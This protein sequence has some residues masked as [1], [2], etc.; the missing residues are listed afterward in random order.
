MQYRTFAL[1][2]RYLRPKG[3]TATSCAAALLLLATGAPA[4]ESQRLHGQVPEIVARLNPVGRLPATNRLH[5][6]L[7]LPLRNKE[8][9]GSLLE[10]IYDP[11][12]TNFHRYLVPEQFAER[13][14]PSEVDY[15]TLVAFART[16]GLVVEN[17]HPNRTLLD[18]MASVGEIERTLHVTMRVYQHPTEA[19]TFYA[20]DVEPSL[21]L[22][23]PVLQISGLDDYAPPRSSIRVKSFDKLG[24][25]TENFGSGTNGWYMGNDFRAAY[26]PGVSLRGAGQTVALM[27]L[28][29]HYTNDITLYKARAGL[30]DVPV[31][32]VLLNGVTGAPYGDTVEASLDIE[33]VISM[34]P[35]ISRLIVYE[36]HAQYDV[37]NR[38]ATDNLAKQVSSSWCQGP[39]R[40]ALTDQVFL[41]FAA[42]GQ[43]GFSCSGDAGALTTEA[44]Y[45]WTSSFVTLVGGTILTTSDIGGSR[46]SETTWP[47]SQGGINL[48]YAIPSWQQT[49][50]MSA[51]QG[52]TT[53]RNVP[54]VAMVADGVLVIANNGVVY[55]VG[56]TSVAAPLWAGFC[57]LINERAAA[58]GQPPVGFLNPALYA[59]GNSGLYA[60]AFHDITAG[61]N[62]NSASP[63]RWS[64]VP[65]YDL[66]TGWGTPTGMGTINVLA[67]FGG[68]MWVDFNYGGTSQ[69]GTYEAPYKTLTQG[70]TSVAPAGMIL[71]KGP[72]S[73]TETMRLDKPMTISGVG[74]P[75]S[76]GHGH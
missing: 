26:A 33:M 47:G 8:E 36:G 43:S 24:G 75:S 22:T 4:L 69:L 15:Q 19:R 23:I 28:G 7:G 58:L 53:M 66:C 76:I 30:P 39:A 37:W 1:S 44:G 70:V 20:P 68:T 10:Q 11:K 12:S 72:G 57:A 21:N 65:G 60:T 46:I 38:I 3:V 31:E 62:T 50:D 41:Q 73:S 45:P 18:V 32:L 9:L 14:G 2:V 61:S 52:S 6:V 35:G 29:G 49:T 17:I 71:I 64:A 56:G 34:A 74:G 54:D 5:L 27:A 42:Q 51:N 67:L 59:I 40:N 48:T 16:N 13:F 63:S 55:G 25:P